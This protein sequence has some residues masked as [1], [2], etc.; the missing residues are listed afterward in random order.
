MQTELSIIQRQSEAL[1]A[2]QWAS[3]LGITPKAFQLRGI[4]IAGRTRLQGGLTNLYGFADLPDATRRDLDKKRLDNRCL[5][6]RDLLDVMGRAEAAI[7]E[8]KANLKNLSSG[9]FTDFG[10]FPADAQ[11]IAHLRMK[12][13]AVYYEALD[14]G[15]LEKN[16][17]ALAQQTWQT[18]ARTMTLADGSPLSPSMRNCCYKK[19]QRLRDKIDKLGGS[20]APKEAYLDGKSCRHANARRELPRALVRDFHARITDSRS[21]VPSVAAIHRDYVSAWDAGAELPGLGAKIAPNEPFPVTISQ[22]QRIAPGRAVREIAGRGKFAARTKALLAAPPLD[23][24]NVEPMRVVMFDDKMLD[25]LVLT[26]DGLRAFR[27][28]IYIAQCAGTKQVLAFVAREEGR[29][30]QLDVEGLQAAVLRDHGFH[31]PSIW[32]M[33]KGTVSISRLRREFLERMFHP[34]LVVHD[35]SMIS[36]RNAPGDWRQAAKGSFWG[37]L[38]LEAFM[39]QLDNLAHTIPGQTGNEYQQ[40]PAILGDTT[41][42]LESIINSAKQTRRVS[43]ASSSSYSLIPKNRP[44][45]SLLE[46][47]ILTAAMSRVIAWSENMGNLSAVEAAMTTGVRPPMLYYRDFVALLGELFRCYNNRRGHAMQGFETIRVPHPNNSPQISQI[48]ADSDSENNLRQSGPRESAD[49]NSLCRVQYVTE[50]PNDKARRMLERMHLAGRKIRRPSDENIGLMLHKLARPVVTANGAVV[51][52]I[53]YWHKSSRA[54]ND[55][56]SISGGKKVF[57]ALYN[58]VAPEALYLLVNPPG[59]INASATELPK[60]FKPQLYEVLPRYVAPDPTNPDAMRERSHAVEEF[61][62]PLARAVAVYKEP[63]LRQQGAR[64]KELRD[65]LEPLRSTVMSARPDIAP[66]TIDCG[67]LGKD[68]EAAERVILQSGD[69]APAPKIADIEDFL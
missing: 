56:R 43:S 21:G 5:N 1:T 51:N 62:A 26:D 31:E 23:W 9:R 69:Q 12:A 34:Y 7:T 55:A 10:Q 14:R 50:S 19:I 53:R 65:R 36:G 17:N 54:Q 20:R 68:V 27:P 6:F 48:F 8:A 58:P 64:R 24:S 37:K 32:V 63:M 67:S 52:G 25:C 33:E 45:G 18:E 44:S 39:W 16:A 28:V 4:P 40:Q 35:T 11:Q 41:L 42:S 61:N 59:H 13:M 15:V 49:K 60:N 30:T 46:E 38:R 29:M 47:S 2:R 22:L 57:L 66:E 3:L